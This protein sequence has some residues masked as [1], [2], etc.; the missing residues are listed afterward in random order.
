MLELM[1]KVNCQDEALDFYTIKGKNDQ[2]YCLVAFNI[3][4]VG[5]NPFHLNHAR[6]QYLCS[7]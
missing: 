1:H 7:S 4:R 5:P 6:I 3:K 2:I